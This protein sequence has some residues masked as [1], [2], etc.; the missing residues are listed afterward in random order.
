MDI[1]ATRHRGRH[2]PHDDHQDAGMSSEERIMNGAG[3][4]PFIQVLFA[5]TLVFAVLYFARIVFEPIAFALFGMAIIW[6]FQKAVESKMPKPAAL[7]LTILLTLFVIFVLASAII[8]STGDIIHWVFTNVARFQSLYMRTNQWLEGHG[9][10]VTEGLGP[11]DVRAFIGVAQGVAMG[12]NYF[13]G[14]CVIV[15]LLLT[16]G[17]IELSV[18]RL[19]VEELQST[20]DWN[21]SQTVDEIARRIRKYMLIRTLASVVTGVAVFAFTFI[22]GLDLAIE[23]GVISF[24]LNYI[25][26]IGPLI[27]VVFPVLFATAQFQSWPMAMAIFVGL[28][29]IQFSIGNYFEPVITGK[30]LS[31]SPFVMLVAFFFWAFLWGIPGAFI[32]L[33]VTIAIFTVCE[34]NRSSRWI[35]RLL[36]TSG[37]PLVN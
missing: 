29:T 32:G 26:Y 23:W 37:A 19:H 33:P 22:M 9:I 14:F 20:I 2:D 16:F 10:F 36:S 3:M 5:V 11:Y 30:A 7:I 17:V 25:P 35:V 13:I 21:V 1:T 28:Y 34:Q 27:A 8:W 31:I 15:F 24:V 12:V 6:P 4:T 18:F